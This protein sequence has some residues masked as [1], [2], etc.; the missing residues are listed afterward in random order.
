MISEPLNNLLALLSTIA[1]TFI[2]TLDVAGLSALLL[3]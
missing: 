2:M 3:A 1:L